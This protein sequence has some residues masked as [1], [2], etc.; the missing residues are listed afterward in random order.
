MLKNICILINSS[1]CSYCYCALLCTNAHGQWPARLWT[2]DSSV[3][4]VETV[5]FIG[6]EQVSISLSKHLSSKH[7]P[8]RSQRPDWPLRLHSS[9]ERGLLVF[10]LKLQVSV[11]QW[12]GA[13]QGGKQS[14][15]SSLINITSEGTTISSHRCSP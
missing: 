13:E 15:I 5:G 7:R 14:G 3:Y 9:L 11:C 12:L 1:L 8:H 10:V 4:S 2:V 6:L